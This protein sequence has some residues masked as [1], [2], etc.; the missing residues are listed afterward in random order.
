MQRFA[1]R[2]NIKSRNLQCE[3]TFDYLLIHASGQK[4]WI[5]GQTQSLAA[6]YHFRGLC[7]TARDA[8]RI[9][10]TLSHTYTSEEILSVHKIPKYTAGQ[11]GKDWQHKT[12]KHPRWRIK[13]PFQFQSGVKTSV[14]Q[15]L[16]GVKMQSLCCLDEACCRV[17]SLLKM[18][19]PVLLLD[20]EGKARAQNALHRFRVTG[21]S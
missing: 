5:T 6:F 4:C 12:S 19:L 1:T 2:R 7:V 17:T 21:W 9:Q 20:F 16:Q 3:S 11:Y 8:Y 18:L 10:T 14:H 13:K 15:T